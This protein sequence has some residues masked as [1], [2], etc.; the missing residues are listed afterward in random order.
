VALRADDKELRTSEQELQATNDELSTGNDELSNRNLELGRLNDDLGNVL[1][2]VDVPIVIV[3]SGGRLRR[4]TPAAERSLNIAASDVGRPIEDLRLSVEIPELGAMLRAVADTLTFEEREVQGR[5]GR[6]YSMRIR[7]YR[8]AENQVDGA[9]I[10]FIDIDALKRA[11]RVS[12]AARAEAEAMLE[13][14]REPFVILDADLRVVQANRSFY[15]R[16]QVTAVVTEGQLIYDLDNRQWDIPQ[17]RALLENVIPQDGVVRDF[18]VIHD[19]ERIGRRSMRLNAARVATDAGERVLILLAIEDVTDAKHLEEARAALVER[20]Q[21]LRVAAEAA[22]EAKDRFVAV[23]SHELRTPLQAMLGWIRLLRSQQLGAKH[24]ERALAVI[25]RNTLLQ[26]RLVEDL[27][28]VSR[29]SAGMLQLVLAPIAIGPAVEAAADGLRPAAAAK[30]IRFAV[31]IEDDAG[32]IHGD[33][34]RLGQMVANLLGN[35]IKFTPS[36]GRIELRLARRGS[37]AEITVRDTGAGIVPDELSQIIAPF[38]T[39]P[40]TRSQGGLGLGL[41]ITRHLAELHGG[42]L[43]AASAGLD[44]GA[45]FTLTFPLTTERPAVDRPPEHGAAPLVPPDL[46]GL[47]VLVVEDNADTRDVIVVMLEGSGA[48]VTAAD[49]VEAALAAIETV[50]PD[51]LMS[52]LTMPKRD[53]YD[54]IRSVRA[55]DPDCGGMLPAIA[56]TASARSEDRERVISAGFQRYLSKPID[57]DELIAAIAALVDRT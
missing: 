37:Q 47:R 1:T 26:A 19:F 27:L 16:F 6:W 55:L 17:L 35:A 31:S 7:P 42:A 23:L 45:T 5:D 53:G 24:A 38:G 13:T 54:L 29:I 12:E 51:V 30:G 43:H 33:A 22:T 52:D 8:T 46:A 15:E 39:R 4:V 40:R 18:E 10:S 44:Q 11:Q 14:L 41:G 20:E 36:G 49:T 21:A 57:F 2:S 32:S 9:V 25:E 34:V 48:L 3:G 28:D 50:V 56:L